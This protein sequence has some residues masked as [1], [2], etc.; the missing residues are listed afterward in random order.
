LII[1]PDK[2]VDLE[3][4]QER[5]TLLAAAPEMVKIGESLASE[6]KY[7]E[8]VAKLKTAKAWNP[9]LEINPE[10][11]A[12]SVR[13]VFTGGEKAEKGDLEGAIKDFQQAL[14]LDPKVD[15]EPDTEGM[16]NNP[17][18]TAKKLNTD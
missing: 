11:I 9:Q 4:C 16:Q 13:L 1:Y 7:E 3:V 10:K 2:L 6:G 15:L 14:K 18:Q 17:T 8:G 12:K 5:S